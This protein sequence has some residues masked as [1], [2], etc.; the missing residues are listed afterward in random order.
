LAGLRSEAELSKAISGHNLPDSE[1]AEVIM[2]VSVVGE[3]LSVNRDFNAK[4]FA[5]I[6]SC[7]SE[8]GRLPRM[9]RKLV[10]QGP[11][12]EA[13]GRQGIVVRSKIGK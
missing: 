12:M 13:G 4:E 2:F 8:F 9:G 3:L 1:P 7:R 6:S 11:Q 10:R 5:A